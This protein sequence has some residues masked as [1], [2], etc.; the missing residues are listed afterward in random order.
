MARAWDT[1]RVF[2][3]STFRHMHAEGNHLARV[4]LPELWE[5]CAKRQ[6]HVVDLNLRWGVTE[7]EAEQ[8][9]V[10]KV[11]LNEKPLSQNQGIGGSN[12][13]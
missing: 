8:G 12:R 10:L 9:R 2:I 11:I 7:E 5:R 1:V 13:N 3:S 6:S 4:I